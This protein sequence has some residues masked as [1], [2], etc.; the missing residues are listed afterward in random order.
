MAD[1]IINIITDAVAD[2]VEITV[3]Q[4]PETLVH[5]VQEV[6]VIAPPTAIP[7]DAVVDGGIIF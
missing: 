5:F 6:M 4:P 3:Q 1:E 7:P 2:T